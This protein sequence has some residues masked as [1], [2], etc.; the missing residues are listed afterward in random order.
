VPCDTLRQDLVGFGNIGEP[1][2][3]DTEEDVGDLLHVG[4]ADEDL[5]ELFNGFHGHPLIQKAQPFIKFCLK[6][7]RVQLEGLRERF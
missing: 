3:G 1:F 6:V 7:V 2:V 4:P 5:V